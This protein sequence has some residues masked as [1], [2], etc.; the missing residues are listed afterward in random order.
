MLWFLPPLKRCCGEMRRSGDTDEI[1]ADSADS[2]TVGTEEKTQS[3]R[4]EQEQER[5]VRGAH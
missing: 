2:A 4:R 1:R 5:G 3:L